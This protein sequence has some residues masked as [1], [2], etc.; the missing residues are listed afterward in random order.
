MFHPIS[1]ADSAEPDE[2]GEG[3]GDGA[4]GGA[5]GHRGAL[6]SDPRHQG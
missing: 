4:G 3:R 5:D 6:H 2:R 1:K